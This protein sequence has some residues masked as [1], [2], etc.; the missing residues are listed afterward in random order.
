M[1]TS[2]KVV[3]A[4]RNKGYTFEGFVYSVI[5]AGIILTWI[6]LSL[7]GSSGWGVLVSGYSIMLGCLVFLG[8]L[9]LSSNS[10]NRVPN[11]VIFWNFIPIGI[12]LFTISVLLVFINQYKDIIQSDHL[13]S[14]YYTF[15][16]LMSFFITLQIIMLGNDYMSAAYK[17]MQKISD[18]TFMLFMLLSILNLYFLICY[19]I[20]LK[21]YTTQ[22]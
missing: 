6:G 13:S 14:Y 18:T 1:I 19:V 20:V 15:S 9:K 11:G 16:G 5:S 22:G 8:A 3:N 12:L 10:N 17:T 4:E 7:N 21:F 2:S